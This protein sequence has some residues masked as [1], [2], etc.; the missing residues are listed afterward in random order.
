MNYVAKHGMIKGAYTVVY[1]GE[2][3]PEPDQLKKAVAAFELYPHIACF[4]AVL[5]WRNENQNWYTRMVALSYANNFNSMLRGLAATGGV[6]PLGGTSNHI[7]TRVLASLNFWDMFNVTEDL[8]LGVAMALADYKCMILPSITWEEASITFVRQMK[9]NSRWIKGH[10]A[11]AIAFTKDPIFLA[12]KFGP[13]GLLSFYSVVFAAHPAMIA[14]PMF[15]AMTIVYALTG[16]DVIQQVT[17]SFA[18]YIGTLCLLTNAVFIWT[19]GLALLRSGQF[20]LWP[21]IFTLPIYW[22]SVLT[23]GSLKAVYEIFTGRLY[24]WDKTEHGLADHEEELFPA[25]L[26]ALG[27]D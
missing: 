19:V 6:F 9:Q 4:Q 10:T 3:A 24:Y 8:G 18:F 1:D 17:P 26:V 15:W 27:D 7:R 2:D 22:A 14:A 11:T 16:A 25:L 23:I 12:R 5:R 13:K 21:W 20:K